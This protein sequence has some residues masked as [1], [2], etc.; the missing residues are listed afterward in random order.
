MYRGPRDVDAGAWGAHEHSAGAG[1][2]AWLPVGVA[3]TAS[4]VRE[5]MEK[6]L[7]QWR[8]PGRAEGKTL[9]SPGD[10][11]RAATWALDADRCVGHP[12]LCA[13]ALGVLESAAETVAASADVRDA[14]AGAR[15]GRAQRV[16]ARGIS[17]ALGAVAKRVRAHMEGDTG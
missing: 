4:F 15:A 14:P 8:V 1:T 13:W 11:D 3:G 16:R 17:E 9:P 10:A 2:S 7:M 5:V 12:E 6:A